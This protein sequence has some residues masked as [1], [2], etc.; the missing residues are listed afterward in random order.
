MS[1]VFREKR[2]WWGSAKTPREKS[3]ALHMLGDSVRVA[4]HPYERS[5]DSGSGNCWC[6]TDRTRAIHYH[7]FH[8][9]SDP[10]GYCRICG[11]EED[12][13]RHEEV[14]L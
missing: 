7:P 1:P 12:N 10:S 6:G 2:K 8:P 11:C 13:R 9:P 5:P 4:L 14:T 3:T